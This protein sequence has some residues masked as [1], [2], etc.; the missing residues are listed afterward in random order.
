M[1]FIN[2]CG[3]TW[4]LSYFIPLGYY[5]ITSGRFGEALS[6]IFVH[7]FTSMRIFANP[8]LVENAL[9]YGLLAFG[10]GAFILVFLGFVP[11]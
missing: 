8:Q 9:F 7:P 6:E 4:F 2:F 10:L 1:E 5:V 11:I 3:S